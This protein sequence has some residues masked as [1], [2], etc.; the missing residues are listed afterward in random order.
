MNPT[1]VFPEVEAF[2]RVWTYTGNTIFRDNQQMRIKYMLADSSFFT[3][4]SFKLRFAAWRSG[5]F[6]AQ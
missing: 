6:L 4:F 1:E 5:G 3:M 2:T